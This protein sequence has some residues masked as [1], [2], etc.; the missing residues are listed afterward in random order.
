MPNI[1]THLVETKR[2]K[3]IGRNG[4]VYKRMK[5][6][7]HRQVNR[8]NLKNKIV[9]EAKWSKAS[10]T[11]NWAEYDCVCLCV[12]ESQTKQQKRTR[13]IHQQQR[14]STFLR[15]M[16]WL[17]WS[18]FVWLVWRYAVFLRSFE[19]ILPRA[20]QPNNQLLN[21]VLSSSIQTSVSSRYWCTILSLLS[22]LFLSKWT[23]PYI[24]HRTKQ[25]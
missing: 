13:V 10:T 22:S 7:E 24:E 4:R 6:G 15:D 2:K 25:W 23:K 11:L 21:S 8:L 19:G 3:R 17:R 14:A 12:K 18:V 16:F 1:R 9:T 5:E 20:I